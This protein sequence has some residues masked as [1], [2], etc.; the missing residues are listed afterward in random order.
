MVDCTIHVGEAS[1]VITGQYPLELVREITS[2]PVEG[3]QFSHKFKSGYW[4]GRK[5]LFD[6]RH[7]SFPSGLAIEVA[8]AL[9]DADPSAKVRL[10]WGG[11]EVPDPK[12]KGFSLHG[13]EFG[14]G[15][16]D[17]QLKA[18][19]A[20]INAK[21]G[22]IKLATN[23]GKT[24]IAIAVTKAIGHPTLFLVG[25]KELLHQTRAR[26]A[27]RLNVPWS[28]IG[29]VG[30][31]KCVVKNITIASPESYMNRLK[32]CVK[33]PQWVVLFLDECHH[34][35]AEIYYNV[36]AA[37]PAPYRFGM[38][39]TPLDRTDG[40]D[41]RLIAQ[42]G[43]ILYE[44]DNKLLVER[45]ISVEPRVQWIRI[46]EPIIT[47]K[48]LK[49]HEVEK[50]GVIENDRLN[51][52]V[53]EKSVSFA[54]SGKQVL[55]LVEKTEHGKRLEAGL[56]TRR[57]PPYTFIHGKES[58]DKRMS[59]LEDFKNGTLRI[60]VATPILDEGVDVPNIDA[61][62][63]A[64]AGKSKIKLLQRIGRGLRSKP[65]K[66]HLEIV[67]FANFTHKWLL[68]HSLERLKLYRQEECFV[69]TES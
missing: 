33:F 15:K 52:H 19:K 24:E 43:D 4:D 8:R 29:I 5:H 48:K 42:T 32:D 3:H 11:K 66:T 45:G 21:R 1:A 13:I 2:Y 16:Y 31:Q 54:S 10:K 17:Y 20:M 35:G 12:G 9:K 51:E 60:L 57:A 23:S 7:E 69:I 47:D 65:G 44:V 36:A 55:V 38:S 25:R 61:I 6:K 26:F 18:A 58:S 64:G 41:L 46:E 59:A 39:G 49:Y 40:A 63:L 56:K 53:L 27:E 14:K 37:I 62:I 68:K 67:D 30:D 50:R 22:I 28:D 34:A